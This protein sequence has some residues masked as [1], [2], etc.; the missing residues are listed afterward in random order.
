MKYDQVRNI[1]SACYEAEVVSRGMKY[2]PDNYVQKRFH[3]ASK[4]LT[5]SSRP[6][7]LL[8]GG[9]GNGKTTLAK[10]IRRTIATVLEACEA[11]KKGGTGMLPLDELRW[12][13]TMQNVLAVPE[14][15]PATE[16]VRIATIPD[17]FESL[18]RLRFLIIDDMGC[19]PAIAKSYGTEIT[20]L[21][22]IIYSRYDT[23]LPTVIT[24]NL[25]DDG[26]LQRYGERVIDRFNEV[27]DKIA[28]ENGSYRTKR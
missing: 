19:E 14:I 2:I 3:Q 4:W 20:P 1:L 5:S 18:K 24:S 6:C 28:Y 8:Y 7:L 22:D 16:I 10:A 17:R 25:D 21:T 9:V 26:I 27:F 23:L 11:R 13:E 15:Y 12:I